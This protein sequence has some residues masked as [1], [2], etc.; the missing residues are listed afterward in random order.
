MS[1]TSLGSKNAALCRGAIVA[2]NGAK[3]ICESPQKYEGIQKR[4][5]NFHT[6]STIGTQWYESNQFLFRRIVSIGRGNAPPGKTKS[7]KFPFQS[8]SF[9]FVS[10]QKQMTST[11]RILTFTDQLRPHLTG[12][13]GALKPSP[14]IPSKKNNKSRRFFPFEIF[15]VVQQ[16]TQK[17][18]H[19]HTIILAK[20]RGRFFEGIIAIVVGF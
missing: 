11:S 5:A 19:H 10:T 13:Q 8:I 20:H 4:M 14:Y 6:V 12:C 3:M 17:K 1:W 18:L 2:Q 16:T 9:P 7:T 15:V